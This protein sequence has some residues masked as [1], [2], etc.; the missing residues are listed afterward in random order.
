MFESIVN[1]IIPF[2]PLKIYLFGSHAKGTAT[3]HSDVDLCIVINTE[4]KRG[5]LADLYY[6]V[7]YDR[8]V[9]FLV[10]TPSEWEECV[11]DKSS[12]AYKIH[13]EGVLIYGRQ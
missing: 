8:P 11:A 12:F 1:Q 3:E 7:D 10:Y 6:E 9:D 13:T 5:L 4:N 2:S